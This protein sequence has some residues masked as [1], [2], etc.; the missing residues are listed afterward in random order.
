MERYLPDEHICLDSYYNDISPLSK[1]VELWLQLLSHHFYFVFLGLELRSESHVAPRS[2]GQ[3]ENVFHLFTPARTSSR[4]VYHPDLESH[5]AWI[6]SRAP[7]EV[8]DRSV[9]QGNLE[10]FATE[11]AVEM[12]RERQ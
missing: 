6:W 5:A 4:M 9:V 7:R 3:A 12:P 10:W 1:A 11:N 8:H 2:L